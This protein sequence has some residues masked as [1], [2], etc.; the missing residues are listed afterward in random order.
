MHSS[1]EQHSTPKSLGYRLPAEWEKHEA[2][3]LTFPWCNDSFPGKMDAIL[4]SY[5]N[6]IKTISRGEKVRININDTTL[7]T[8]VEGLLKE[9]SID[10]SQ[11]ELFIHRSDD[12]WCRDHGPAFLIN[13]NISER[14][15]IID[16]GFNAWGGKYPSEND[17][18]IPSQIAEHFKL[19]MYKPGIIMEG[20]SVDFNGVGSVLTTEACLLNKNRNPELSKKQIEQYLHDYYCVENILWLNDGIEGDDTD[21]HIDDITRFINSDTVVTAIETSMSDN[22]YMPLKV[23]LHKLSKMHL[24]NGKQLNIIELPMPHKVIHEGQRLPAS[25]ANFY[26]S[27]NAIIVPTFRCKAD[28]KAMSILAKLFPDR[29]VVGIDSVDLVWGFGSFHCLSQQEPA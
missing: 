9:Y 14:K 7:K 6:F 15:A 29:K 13:N 2:T 25:Y 22:N 21:G 5:L 10:E 3:W 17:N 19:P 26:I 27:N 28:D 24:E 1:T 4:P 8:K 12:V 16:W 11:I 18:R 23:N 20:G